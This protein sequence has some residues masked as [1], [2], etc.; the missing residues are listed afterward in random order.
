MKGNCTLIKKRIKKLWQEID[1]SKKR[2]SAFLVTNPKNIF[3]LTEFSGEGILLFTTEDNYLITDSRY[4]EQANQEVHDCQVII[5]EMKQIDAQTES[6]C[7]LI[8][9]LKIKEIGFESDSLQVSTYLKYQNRMPGLNLHPFQNIIE[10]MR[11][12]KD[13]NEIEIMKKSAQIATNS[14]IKTLCSLKIGVSELN[15]AACLNY[16]MRKSGAQKEAFD[17]IVTSGE[18]GTLIHGRPSNKK[19]GEG[20]LI[21]IDFGCV[22]GMYHSDCTRSFVLGDAN[23]EQKKIFDIV[24]KTQIE[25]L[26]QVMA[27]RK[28]SELDSFAR[29]M[30]E[31][32]GYGDYF[33]HSLG[34]GVGLDIHEFPRLS[35]YDQTVLRSGMVVTVEPGIYVPGV[36]G[37]RI[38]DTVVVTE[39]GCQI[40]TQ[41][42]KELS[43][44]TY[45][46]QDFSDIIIA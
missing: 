18:R 46:K 1:K 42:P 8:S 30:I 19:I 44:F 34:H 11:M 28:C 38:E 12:I 24:K 9:E 15:I 3:Y 20:E 36:G 35:A 22:F 45:S 39:E 2:P 6:L 41:L 26:Q 4:T 32:S 33:S 25:T 17:L 43:G 14:F 40:L 13:S 7:K 21:I 16:D 10:T 23:K 37:V 29:K 27:G 31:K 5:Q